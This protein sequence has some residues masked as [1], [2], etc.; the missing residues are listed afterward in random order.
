MKRAYILF[1]LAAVSGWLCFALWSDGPRASAAGPANAAPPAAPSPGANVDRLA[2]ALAS[3]GMTEADLGTRPEGYWYRYPDRVPYKMHFFDSL[4]AQPLRIY[5]FTRVMADCVADN[6]ALDKL[7]AAPH[8]LYSALFYLGIDHKV[9]GF[10]N[11]GANLDPDLPK[12]S[13]LLW[14]AKQAYDAAG[15]RMER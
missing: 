3:V 15:Q 11:F 5:E 9:G 2:E 12:D 14:A 7:A 8:S 13:P 1:A 10:R 6:I 4:H